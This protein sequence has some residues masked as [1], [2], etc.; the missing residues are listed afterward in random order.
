MRILSLLCLLLSVSSTAAPAGSVPAG[1][2]NRLTV[3]LFN[4]NSSVSDAWMKATAIPWDY[5][6][7]YLT[8]QWAFNWNPAGVRDGAF[9]GAFFRKCAT[10]GYMPAIAYYEMN[11]IPPTNTGFY[12]KVKSPLVMKEYFSDFKLLMQQAKTFDKPVLVLLE[13]D[14]YAYLQG[15]AVTP[16]AVAAVASTG[17]PELANLPNTAAGWGLAFLQIRKS[18]GAN[19]VILGIHISGW[20]GK[21]IF[22]FSV[23]DPIQPFVDNVYAFLGP[24]GLQPNITGQTYDVLVGDPLDRDADFYRLTQSQDRWWDA[25]DMASINS[26][27]FNRYIEWLRLWNVKSSKRWVLWQIPVGNTN[28]KNICYNGT[29]GS[30]YKDNR[31]EYIF[32]SGGAAHRQKLVEAG[33]IS[34]LFGSGESCQARPEVDGDYLKTN[35]KAFYAA[36]GLPFAAVDAG[37]P[38]T[39]PIVDAGTPIVDAGSCQCVCPPPDAGVI[40][41]DAGVPLVDSGV[42][43]VDAGVPDAGPPV[44]PPSTLAQYDFETTIQGFTS[45]GVAS[46]ALSITSLSAVSGTK[47]LMVRATISAV[48]GHYITVANPV[49]LG[50]STV[51]YN[52]YIPAGI[53]L[54]SVQPFMQ[55]TSTN[56]WRYTAGW[57]PLSSL[58]VGQWNVMSIT[59]PADAT[60]FQSL[61]VQFNF[62]A[63]WTGDILIDAIRVTPKGVVVDAGTPPVIDAGIQTP[64]AG[65]PVT[66]PVIRVMPLGDSITAE[67]RSWRCALYKSLTATGR[68]VQFVG[69]QHDQ[70]DSCASEHEGHPG[71]TSGN[72][73][74]GLDTWLPSYTPDVV[75]AMMGTNDLA[76]WTAE[77][78][79]AIANRLDA[80]ITKIQTLRPG[81]RIV[82]ATIP[83]QSSAIIAPNSVDR[84]VLVAQFNTRVKTIVATRVLAGQ[85]IQLADINSA[86]TLTDLRDGIHPTTT[87]GIAKMAPVFHTAVQA[88]LAKQ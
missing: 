7:A 72:L 77:T 5:R 82:V 21:D 67:S 1:H 4:N 63:P 85:R 8:Y 32:G 16:N 36:G 75:V 78:G 83:P 18:V 28:S 19:K 51:T 88:V 41:P 58:K 6:Y 53:L 23:V 56:G 38:V 10:D 80:I 39:P 74:D 49:I 52:V 33:V 87:A 26:K 9:A 81:V 15:E 2:P 86:L 55:E 71:F 22:H 34:L 20:V 3:G 62:S 73:G 44:V 35:V 14:G 69:S 12:A 57:F 66:G 42:P 61:G 64:D 50:G 84:T 70:Y 68:N 43:F 30:G 24:L 46:S 45:T 47:S 13:A 76:W 31:S 60:K 40:V 29:L 37:A 17:L 65:T 48:G 79:T 54:S 59:A 27:S 11:D 25:S